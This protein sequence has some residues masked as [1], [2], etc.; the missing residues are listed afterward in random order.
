MTTKTHI[1]T[2]FAC[3]LPFLNSNNIT[4]ISLVLVGSILP[5]IDIKMGMKHRGF[6]HSL[7][8]FLILA[9]GLFLRDF[10]VGLFFSIGY[11]SHLLLDCLTQK[12]IQFFFPFEKRIG[13]KI[14]KTNGIVD[15]LIRYIAII[16]IC[17]RF[18]RV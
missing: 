4:L 7:L 6:T 3:S 12:G 14:L 5:D 13:I 1:T 2:G 8:C 16:F 18:I 11:I 15:H 9:Y 10:E 17:L